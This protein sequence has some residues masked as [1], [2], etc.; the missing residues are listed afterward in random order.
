MRIPV[1]ANNNIAVQCRTWK[2]DATG[3]NLAQGD[4]TH[5][6]L[7]RELS[8][9]HA[10]YYTGS[11][12]SDLG[13]LITNSI[14]QKIEVADIIF[15][16]SEDIWVN[17]S[18]VGN[19]VAVHFDYAGYANQ[20]RVSANVGVAYIDNLIVRNYRTTEPAW[21]AWGEE[22]LNTQ[23]NIGGV[24]T[25]PSQNRI[26]IGGAWKVMNLIKIAIGGIWKNVG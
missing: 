7:V 2:E 17:D 3:I 4:G 19:D 13:L 1:T 25:G 22:V 10:D 14:W 6:W 24:W 8:T 9:E 16:T 12:Y 18:K 23:I 21:G 5:Y 15:G 26:N 11:T 20:V